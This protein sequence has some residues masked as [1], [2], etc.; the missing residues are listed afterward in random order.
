MCVC[1]C[2][3]YE[4]LYCIYVNDT[5]QICSR[6]VQKKILFRLHNLHYNLFLYYTQR[7]CAKYIFFYCGLFIIIPQLIDLF[8]GQNCI[9]SLLVCSEETAQKP[10][11]VNLL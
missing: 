11:V 5:S 4:I 6:Q 7:V 10:N 3:H 9:I 2:I 1:T 8:V